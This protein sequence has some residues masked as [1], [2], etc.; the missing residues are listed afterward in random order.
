MALIKIL[1]C[2]DSGMT[3]TKCCLS[4]YPI[5]FV[6]P[7]AKKEKST[8]CSSFLWKIPCGNSSGFMV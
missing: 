6:L 8:S 7:T 3:F 2:E 5:G 4:S 1:V